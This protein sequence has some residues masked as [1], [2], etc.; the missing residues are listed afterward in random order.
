MVYFQY[1]VVKIDLCT[2]GKLA[3]LHYSDMMHRVIVLNDFLIH[4]KIQTLL[5]PQLILIK[6]TVVK[7]SLLPCLVLVLLLTMEIKPLWVKQ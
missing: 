3:P 1:P 2:G 5:A 4:H 6:V 7:L